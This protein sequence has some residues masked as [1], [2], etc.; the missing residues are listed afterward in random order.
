MQVDFSYLH[1]ILLGFLHQS[2]CSKVEN[3]DN[4]GL[5]QRL[6]THLTVPTSH[7]AHPQRQGSLPVRN[8]VPEKL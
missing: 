5:L 1:T 3:S 4:A 8:P 2:Y 7:L 6:Q